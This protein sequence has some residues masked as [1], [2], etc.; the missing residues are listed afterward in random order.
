MKSAASTCSASVALAVIGFFGL[1][2]VDTGFADWWR[3]V[4]GWGLLICWALLVSTLVLVYRR[5]KSKLPPPPT[6]QS[7]WGSG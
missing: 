2:I 4:G 3:F 7:P 5:L 6:Y 1:L